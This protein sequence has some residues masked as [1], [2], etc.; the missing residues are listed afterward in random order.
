M[1]RLCQSVATEWLGL[2]LCWWTNLS[3]YLPI[4]YERIFRL[5][6]IA[7]GWQLHTARSPL[8]LLPDLA[9]RLTPFKG[10][11]GKC[12]RSPRANVRCA[13]GQCAARPSAGVLESLGCKWTK[14]DGSTLAELIY[15]AM[16][17]YKGKLRM[18]SNRKISSTQAM[19]TIAPYCACVNRQLRRSGSKF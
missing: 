11:L 14:I 1:A 15:I 18:R 16:E 5:R 7:P 19:S 6:V 13:N 9:S 12:Y 4:Q 17:W 8:R 10:H 3:Q 2:C